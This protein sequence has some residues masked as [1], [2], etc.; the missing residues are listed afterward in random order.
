[1]AERTTEVQSASPEGDA[2]QRRHVGVRTLVPAL[3][4]AIAYLDPGNFGVNI[5][6]GAEHGYALVWVVVFASCSAMVIQYLAAK[7]GMATGR[8]LA[9]LSS[10]RYPGWGACSC[11]RRPRSSS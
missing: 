1:M 5:T 7:L 9:E 11:G 8:S 2:E 6:S 10:E 4:A 3:L